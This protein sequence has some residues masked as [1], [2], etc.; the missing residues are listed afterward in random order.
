MF[1]L[2]PP[3]LS[4]VERVGST[5]CNRYTNIPTPPIHQY[6]NAPIH[7]FH[8]LRQ[9]TKMVPN[10]ASKP[11][12]WHQ[13]WPQSLPVGTKIA[14]LASCWHPDSP[15]KPQASKLCGYIASRLG[16]KWPLSLVASP[17]A[18]PKGCIGVQSTPLRCFQCD[19]QETLKCVKTV[20]L[21]SISLF[22]PF[23]G[24]V[25][26]PCGHHGSP[27]VPNVTPLVPQSH[28]LGSQMADIV[29][30]WGAHGATQAPQECQI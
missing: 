30:L 11:P 23:Q 18:R 29:T 4:A 2:Y 27:K 12:L 26:A 28:P 19:P 16:A 8:Q 1:A 3:T 9:S 5:L 15:T 14:Y 20:E 24:R 22:W 10:I 7:Q 17:R 6:T 25:L 13:Q 21:L